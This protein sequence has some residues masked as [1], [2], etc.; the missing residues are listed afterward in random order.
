M[1]TTTTARAGAPRMAPPSL[2]RLTG[3]E[4]R[5]L[6]DTRAGYWLLITIGLLAAA[7]ATVQL[8]VPDARARSFADFF[9]ASLLPVGVLLP[10]LGIL[11][12]TSE[13]SQRTTLTTFALVPRRHRVVLAKLAAGTVAGVASVGISLAVAA[14][15]TVI[16][17]VAGGD[18]SWS[19]EAAAI[20]HAAVLQATGVLTGLAFGMLLL[21]T[22]L[23]VVLYFLLPTV[24]G[25]LGDMIPALRAPAQW[26]DTGVTLMPLATP[27]V[28]AGQWARV[29]VSL[30]VW[31]LAPLL[32][33]VVRVVRAEVC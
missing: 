8:V 28:T 24:W 12:V 29:A 25:L 5:K 18:V 19:F 17:N 16:G 20:G 9:S 10:V 2:V 21:H 30:A 7:I 13:W 15:G 6:A 14:A 11:S 31:M 27:D 32:A 3:V 33:G 1:T 22:P 4:L 23:A 26:L